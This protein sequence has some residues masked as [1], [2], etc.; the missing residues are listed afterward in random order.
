[1]ESSLIFRYTNTNCLYPNFIIDP[2]VLNQWKTL[3]CL[4]FKYMLK[5]DVK[6][7]LL[8]K[9]LQKTCEFIVERPQADDNYS[10]KPVS[11]NIN[12]ES[13]QNVKEVSCV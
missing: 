13:L 7:G 4:H 8:S 5:A 11:F 1:M 6:R 2:K 3:L 10:P 12:P 9:D